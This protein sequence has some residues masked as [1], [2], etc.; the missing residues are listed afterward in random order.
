[1]RKTEARLSPNHTNV[2]D[3]GREWEMKKIYYGKSEWVIIGK[4]FFKG[5]SAIFMMANFSGM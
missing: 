5:K 2:W 3:S 4:S 1:M